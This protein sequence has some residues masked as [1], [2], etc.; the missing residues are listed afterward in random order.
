L[1]DHEVAPVT[2]HKNRLPPFVPLL[3]DTLDSPAWRAMS[4]GARS[5]YVSLKR[6][7]PKGRNTAYLSYRHAEDELRSSQRRIGDGF[8]ELQFYGFIVLEQLGCLGLDGKGKS[9]LWRLTEL[10]VTSNASRD[11]LPEPATR[12]FLKW[13]GVPFKRTGDRRVARFETF[14]KKQNPASGVGSRVHTASEAVP[15]RRRKRPNPKVLP[16]G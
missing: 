10:G 12:D 11:G 7:V 5:L 4:H 15:L 9:P 14:L 13:D 2:K 1:L 6:R 8:R 16:A 3:T